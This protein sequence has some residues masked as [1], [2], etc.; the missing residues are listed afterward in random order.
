M[1]PKIIHQIWLSGNGGTPLPEKFRRYGQTFRALFPDWEYRLWQDREATELITKEFPQH[2]AGFSSLAT[3]AQKAD[4][5]RY[6]IVCVQGGFYVDTDCECRRAFDFISPQD[7][8]IVAPE[9]RTHS[10]RVMAL[11][12][13]DLHELYCQW[14]FLAR[15]RHPFLVKLIEEVGGNVYKKFSDN[16]ML[17]PLKRTGPHVFTKVFQEYLRQGGQATVV[18]GSYFG[19]CNGRN[20]FTFAVTFLLPGLFRKLY[21]RHEFTGSWI[22]K[23]YKQEMLKRNMFMLKPKKP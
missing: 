13:T 5:L 4:F 2:L 16:P 7:E 18:P 10:D 1:I 15:P 21:V 8:L 19:C 3:A 6:M 23:E 20:N 22:D 12:P 9:L 14:A 11:Y 17:D